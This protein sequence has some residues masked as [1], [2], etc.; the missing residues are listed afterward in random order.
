[1][2]L[3]LENASK[4]FRRQ[5]RDCLALD[6]VSLEVDRGQMVG[7]F[8]PSRAGKTTLLRI[9]AGLLRQ[10]G[11]SVLFDGE[12]LDAM[13]RRSWKH[14]RRC[15]VGCI[16]S[17]PQIRDG[18]SVLENVAFPLLAARHDHAVAKRRAREALAACG[19]EHCVGM[20]TRELSDGELQRVAIAR[21]L[22]IEP[23]LLLADAPA[24]RLSPAEQ[25]QIMELLASF[26]Q[27]AKGAVLVADANPELLLRA[28]P[29]LYLRDGELINPSSS[30]QG[31]GKVYD[32]SK[33]LGRAA[34]DA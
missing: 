10:D 31:G 20:A 16:W 12:R 30:E 9:S 2:I 24:S 23:R 7:I 29:I 1:V 33:R 13:S 3:R 34:S 17:D 6:N 28:A 15:E 21:A 19:A 11:G 25:E 32:L 18:F 26:A 8:G 14:F 27:D 4:R 5:G 22:A